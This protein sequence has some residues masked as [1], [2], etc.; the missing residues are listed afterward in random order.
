VA[1]AVAVREALRPALGVSAEALDAYL[2]AQARRKNAVLPELERDNWFRIAVVTQMLDA[3]FEPAV[4]QSLMTGAIDRARHV[5]ADLSPGLPG[6][7]GIEQ[8]QATAQ[9]A[10]PHISSEAPAGVGAAVNA[11]GATGTAPARKRVLLIVDYF[12]RWPEWFDVFLLS[13]AHNPEV[14]WLI[15]TDCPLPAR[16]PENVRFVQQSFADYCARASDRLDLQFSPYRREDGKPPVPLYGNLCD[17]RPCYADLHAEAIEGYDYFGWCDIDVVFGKLRRFLTPEVLDRNLITFSG[18]F[19]GGHFTLLKNTPAMRRMY[20]DIP[21]WRRRIEGRNGP[22]PWDDCLDE[23]WLTRLCSPPAL[24]FRAEG[25]AQGVPEQVIDRY[26]WHNAFIPEC[27]TPFTPNNWRDGQR[28]HPEVWF[29]RRGE[30]TNWRDG[31]H[32]FPYL[33]MMNFKQQR[34]IDQALYGMQ[35]TWERQCPVDPGALAAEVIRID[36]H[37][38]TGLSLE[39]AAAEQRQLREHQRVAQGIDTSGLSVQ[40]ALEALRPAGV[41]YQQGVLDDRAGVV[42][43]A[44]RERLWQERLEGEAHAER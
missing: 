38:I 23:A 30:L 35:A 32:P 31:E 25:L 7:N 16:H 40:Q 28:L 33:H 19:C 11:Q 15:H 3:D 12:G 10:V 41:A 6:A 37:G 27:V 26:R 29:W 18:G 13:C 43:P 24:P 5:L 1:A 14:D 8:I 4:V 42:P 17:L 20:R 36:R 2:G 9:G 22:T 34:H 44:F 39:A 21:G